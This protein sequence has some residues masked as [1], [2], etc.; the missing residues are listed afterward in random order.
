VSDDLCG[1]HFS[2]WRALTPAQRSALT[3]ALMRRAHVARSRAIG[4]AL[5]G[6]LVALFGRST[7]LLVPAATRA[8]VR[9]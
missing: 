6:T 4:R 7:H 8:S 9:R 2:D 3:I 1:F 5:L